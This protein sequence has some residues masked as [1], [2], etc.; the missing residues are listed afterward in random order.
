[1]LGRKIS[2]PYGVEMGGQALG[3]GFLDVV[4]ELLPHKSTVLVDAHPLS[5]DTLPG[6]MVSG[7]EIHM[8]RTVR[9][10]VRPCFHIVHRDGLS[11]SETASISTE[12]NE[13]GA[14][15]G[16]LFIW[17]TYIHGVFDGPA[18]RRQWLNFVRGRKR[19]D[20]LDPA[21][22]EAVST[23]LGAA[24]DRWA[25]HLQQHLNVSAIFSALSLAARRR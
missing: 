6:T 20:S 10:E 19:L 25:D 18:F 15:H 14:S 13:D 16:K 12:E 3:L 23:R 17:G 5:W 7:Y 1:M 11:F 8:G 9:G 24:L 4:T 21:V 22:S 2:D